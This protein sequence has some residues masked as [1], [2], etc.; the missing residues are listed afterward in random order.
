MTW[1]C[2][3]LPLQYS[4]NICFFRLTREKSELDRI[5]AMT[6]D[7]RKQYLRANPKFIT[8]M[9]IHTTRCFSLLEILPNGWIS[10]SNNFFFLIFFFFLLFESSILFYF[11]S[12]KRENTNSC[13]NISIA[14]PFS[15]ISKRTFINAI[16]LNLLL[17][18]NLTNQFYRKLCRFVGTKLF[19][20]CLLSFICSFSDNKI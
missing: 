6:E 13:K 20:I 17:T 4:V 12:K 18:T 7:E 1:Y 3:G 19:I 15:W 11:Y 9:V 14:V 10:H 5:H 8:N 16:S 2:S